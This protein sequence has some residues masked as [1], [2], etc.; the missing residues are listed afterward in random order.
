MKT[1]EKYST[2]CTLFHVK[3]GHWMGS[4][5]TGWDPLEATRAAHCFSFFKTNAVRSQDHAASSPLAPQGRAVL[6]IQELLMPWR[7]GGGGGGALSGFQKK[8]RVLFGLHELFPLS[9]QRGFQRS[10]SAFACMI[11]QSN[12]TL[13]VLLEPP[14][15]PP[16]SQEGWE[17]SGF[18]RSCFFPFFRSSIAPPTPPSA[19]KLL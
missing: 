16:H 14:P 8:K 15:P 3:L 7:G 2:V 18:Q 13:S 9:L 10:E 19:H 11:L 17:L 4:T 1:R 6:E 5:G 12:E